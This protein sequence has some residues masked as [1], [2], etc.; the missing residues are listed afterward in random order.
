[1]IGLGVLQPREEGGLELSL[2]TDVLALALAH[3]HHHRK[4]CDRFGGFAAP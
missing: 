2:L 1:M 4:E 3:S